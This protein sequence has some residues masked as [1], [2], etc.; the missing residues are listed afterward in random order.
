VVTSDIN[1]EKIWSLISEIP[2]P[3]I[4][5]LTLT[6]L[7]IV[8]N[9]VY[10]GDEVE[11][12]ITPTYT[13][14]PAMKV[15]EDDIVAKLNESGYDKVKITRVLSP[16]WTTD[17]MSEEGRK[18]LKEYGITPPVGTSDKTLLQLEK[19]SIQCP[20]CDSMNTEM[21]SQFGSTPCKSLYKCVDCKEPFD[22]FKCI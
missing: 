2:D 21:I 17:W 5:V 22:Y 1:L 18:K 3:E 6:D 7:G 8:K 4:P 12:T 13:G 19:K 20:R 16:A 14:C 11:V 15:F 10:N 9:V